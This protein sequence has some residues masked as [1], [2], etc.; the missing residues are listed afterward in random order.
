VPDQQGRHLFQRLAL[1]TVSI[2][3]VLRDELV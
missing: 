2:V 1:A 3:L